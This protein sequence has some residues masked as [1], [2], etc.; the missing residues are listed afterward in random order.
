ML[1]WN[2]VTELLKDA[3]LKLMQAEEFNNFRLVGISKHG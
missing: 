1:Y 3:L 2:T